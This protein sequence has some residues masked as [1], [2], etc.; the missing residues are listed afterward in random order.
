MSEITFLAASAETSL[1]TGTPNSRIIFS[2]R[3]LAGTIIDWFEP[4]A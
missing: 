2:C 3:L 4:R 1:T